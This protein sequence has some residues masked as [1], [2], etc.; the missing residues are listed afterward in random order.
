MSI[1]KQPGQTL[2][3]HK[4]SVRVT[5]DMSKFYG[6]LASLCGAWPS[7]IKGLPQ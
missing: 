2:S 3:D 5:L 6:E 1:G 7:K 4:P